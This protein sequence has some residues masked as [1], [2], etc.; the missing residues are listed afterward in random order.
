MSRYGCWRA[1]NLL[2][3]IHAM[4]VAVLGTP[5]TLMSHLLHLCH[6]CYTCVTPVTLMSHLLYLCHTL[7]ETLLQT[8]DNS[9]APTRR[10]VAPCSIYTAVVRPVPPLEPST[11][12]SWSW[13]LTRCTDYDSLWHLSWSHTRCT[14]YDFTFLVFIYFKRW[15]TLS[16][17]TLE[18]HYQLQAF[19]AL[20]IPKR[21][22]GGC[23]LS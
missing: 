3:L 16:P 7:A 20:H 12:T 6:T 14:I 15:L 22:D 1:A 11:N 21:Q 2:H 9:V 10:H 18:I 4:P 13:S 5:L 23:F 8:C 17:P 19:Q